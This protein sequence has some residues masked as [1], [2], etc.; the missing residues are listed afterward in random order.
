MSFFSLSAN[1]E[2]NFLQI[3]GLP[4]FTLI[5]KQLH[6]EHWGQEIF[7]IL[8]KFILYSRFSSFRIHYATWWHVWND[9]NCQVIVW[10][11]D[12]SHLRR[13]TQN[14]LGSKYCWSLAYSRSIFGTED[15]SRQAEVTGQQSG[16]SVILK[17]VHLGVGGVCMCDSRSEAGWGTWWRWTGKARGCA[18][19][20]WTWEYL[21]WWRWPGRRACGGGRWGGGAGHGVVVW[22]RWRGCVDRSAGW[23]LGCCWLILHS[24]EVDASTLKGRK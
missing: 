4:L 22:W 7:N 23:S 14:D 16:K 1:V 3:W 24:C 9:C 17:R 2:N 13:E 20:G 6:K 8:N 19:W 21:A 15:H 10:L 5:Q 11:D 12:L 18:G